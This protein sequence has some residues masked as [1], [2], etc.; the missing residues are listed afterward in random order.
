[1]YEWEIKRSHSGK[2]L[3]RKKRAHI[4]SRRKFLMKK[5]RESKL[6]SRKARK[7]KRLRREEKLLS[8]TQVHSGLWW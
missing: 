4:Q 3:A 7:I 1:L 2:K 6:R 5:I 8:K